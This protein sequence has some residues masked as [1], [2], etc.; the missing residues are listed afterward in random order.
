[1]NRNQLSFSQPLRVAEFIA[2][3][4]SPILTAFH[5]DLDTNLLIL[6]FNETV[7]V[8]SLTISEISIQES[9]SINES[10]TSEF[11]FLEDGEILTQDDPS[12]SIRLLP[13]DTN[14]IKR[15]VNLATSDANTF[16]S[17]SNFTIT[18]MNNNFVTL[19]SPDDAFQV[20]NFTE[21]TTSPRL[22][23]YEFDLTLEEIRFVFDETV[24]INSFDVST[25]SLYG[26][27]NTTSYTLTGGEISV[28]QN[29]TLF[30][31]ILTTADLNEVKKIETLATSLENTFISFNS[32]LLMDMNEN[33]VESE[34]RRQANDFVEDRVDP[35]LTSFHLDMNLGRLILTFSETVR[36]SSLSP[37]SISFQNTNDSIAD[38]STNS[39]TIN[40]T[41]FDDDQPEIPVNYTLING[42]TLDDNQPEI[43]VILSELDLNNIKRILNLATSLDDTFLTIQSS[44]IEDMNGNNVTEILPSSALQAENFTED[45][46]NPELEAFD[47][48]LS[49]DILRL[50]FSETVLLSSLNTSFITFVN[51]A[52]LQNISSQYAISTSKVLSGSEDDPVVSIL[53]SRAD[54]N[55]IKRQTDLGTDRN[56]TFLLVGS[57]A[58]SDANF[59]PVVD[60]IQPMQIELYVEDSINPIIEYFVVDMDDRVLYI[61]FSETVNVDSFRVDGL[62]L[63][64]DLGSMGPT[65]TLTP[66]TFPSGFDSAIIPIRLS[67]PDG[68]LLTSLTNLYNS[69]ND[70]YLRAENFTVLDMN[71]NALVPVLG[72][73]AIQAREYLPDVTNAT[74]F[75]FTVD[76]DNFTITLYFNET[77]SSDTI[78]YTKFHAFS[79]E[80]GSINFTLTNGTVDLPYTHLLTLGLIDTDICSI[81]VTERLWTNI[82]DTWLYI[83]SGAIYDWTMMNPLDEITIQTLEVPIENDLPVLLSFSVNLTSGIMT[84]NFDEPVQ[85]LT[86]KWSFIYLQN[87]P[88]PNHTDSYRLRGGTPLTENGKQVRFRFM[89]RDLNV[90][91]SM[92]GLFTNE[93]TSFISLQ[94]GTIRD[95]VLNPSLQIEGLQVSVFVNDSTDPSLMDYSIDMN[96]GQLILTFSETVDVSS[97]YLPAFTLQVDSTISRSNLM[98]FHTFSEDTVAVTSDFMNM[99]DNKIVIVNISLDDLNEIK[100]KRIATSEETTWLTLTRDGLTDNNLQPVLPLMNGIN[101]LPV[102]N[103]TPDTT[104]PEIEG[105]DL[106]LNEGC[107]TLSFSETVDVSTLDVSEIVLLNAES[108]QDSTEFHI[109]TSTSV[110]MPETLSVDEAGSGF[111]E[112]SGAMGLSGSGSGSGSGFGMMGGASDNNNTNDGADD[113]NDLNTM[114]MMMS[115]GSGSGS[116]L[117]ID[118]DRF[119]SL[120]SFNS[121]IIK[122]YFSHFDLNSIKALT[123]LATSRADIFISLSNSTISDMVRNPIVEVNTSQALGVMNYTADTT[124]PILRGFNFDLDSG[125]L[126]LFFTE[127]VNVSSL[128]VTQLTLINVYCMGTNYT[129]RST[130]RYPNTSAAFGADWPIV[131]VRLGHEDLDAVKNLRDLFSGQRNSLLYLTEFAVRDNANNRVV[132]REPCEAP[133]VRDFTHDTTRPQLD[134][135]DLDLDDG[136]LILTFTETVRITDSLNVGEIVIQSTLNPPSD[137]L[138]MYTL[139]NAG[140]FRSNSID[141]DARVVTIMLGFHD[142]N[143][144]KYRSQ[145]ATSENDSY[146]Y[147]SD[148]AILDLAGNRVESVTISSRIFTPD[149]SDPILVNFTLNMDTTTLILTFNETVNASSLMVDQIAIQH[150][151]QSSQSYHSS[152]RFLTPGGNETLTNSDNDYIIVINLGPLDRNE[153]KRRRDLAVSNDTTFLTASVGT[154]LDMNG[155]QLTPIFDGSAQ[156]TIEFV[157]DTSSPVVTDFTLDMDMGVIILTFDET[158]MAD[159]LMESSF[160]L[161]DRVEN[162]S[163][164]FP[165]SGRG[166]SSPQDSTI[167]SIYVHVNDL[168]EIKRLTLCREAR[169]LLPHSR[170]RSYHGHE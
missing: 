41:I 134:S 153:I 71:E 127:T 1:M 34:T 29:D 143:A 158:V 5:L 61:F 22:V 169:Q 51:S 145:L 94:R 80:F 64:D 8:N 138:L 73:F 48:N 109:L 16:I 75:D 100:R 27:Y 112:A 156:Q 28:L 4:I 130:P 10:D 119:R 128:D 18:D 42:T 7:L 162:S 43:T 66:P 15:F 139:T 77:V 23:N 78:D 72:G 46:T 76:L 155:N 6:V 152:P 40:G 166:M 2:D 47:F 9:A 147:I 21:D 161:Q 96:I 35:E 110:Y 125:N 88:F 56:D 114:M 63:Q 90:I 111:V 68:N 129:L 84:L 50:T 98:S 159:S 136:R 30:T 82:S 60:V 67:I 151:R 101:A 140:P 53:L 133:R 102:G 87:T 81:K 17:L 124:D 108:F 20:R 14:Y 104:S 93:S 131:I 121:P 58:I 165:L 164:W 154:I 170:I 49:T 59:N 105:Y 123:N 116:G 37:Q 31:L 83:E 137:S 146:V 13:N 141:P 163:I 115:S 26:D 3:S 126:T 157:P 150:G 107:M 70:S 57:E 97:F 44:L 24:N 54:S 55:E 12:V 79:D 89:T 168:N 106:S 86:I 103:Y 52:D 122:L 148:R 91:K 117:V 69:I 32:S 19:I 135:F 74:L 118:M 36:A 160:S 167:L 99:L 33:Y 62:T 11:R 144:V 120:A 142:L 25:I 39:T 85:P 132:P 149:T 45:S 95:M 65:V 92:T 113:S 38:I